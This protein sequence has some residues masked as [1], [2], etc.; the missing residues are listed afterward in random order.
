METE[1]LY[2]VPSEQLMANYGKKT[3]P[4][5]DEALL[6]E[7]AAKYAA[8]SNGPAEEQVA[9]LLQPRWAWVGITWMTVTMWLHS[10]MQCEAMN[11]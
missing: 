9:N 4:V 1:E 10:Y 11:R 2:G 3:F 6:S 8:E 5:L 7:L